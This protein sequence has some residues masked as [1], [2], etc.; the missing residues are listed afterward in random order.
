MLYRRDY[1]ALSPVALPN[2]RS[3]RRE[4][5]SFDR[6][7]KVYAA[8][9]IL[10]AKPLTQPGSCDGWCHPT[11]HDAHYPPQNYSIG[12][13]S[14]MPSAASQQANKATSLPPF[15]TRRDP[16][17]PTAK[18]KGQELHLPCT[19]GSGWEQ[20]P[21]VCFKSQTPTNG[22]FEKEIN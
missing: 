13:A 17:V 19:P 11:C 6:V 2:L 7:H 1:K 21:L 14:G 12:R 22:Q 9:S 10:C 5:C 4:G 16:Q 8:C 18:F 15:S 20:R 3:R